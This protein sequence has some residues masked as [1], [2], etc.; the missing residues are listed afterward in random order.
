MYLIGWVIGYPLA[1]G[2]F[3]FSLK[4]IEVSIAYAIWS[5]I[6]TIATSVLGVMPFKE[7]IGFIKIFYIAPLTIGLVGLNLV[8]Q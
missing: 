6:G 8:K 5:G 1:F 7:S 3:G 4:E 2:F